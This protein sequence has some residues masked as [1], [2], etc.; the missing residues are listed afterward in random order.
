MQL[1]FVQAASLDI[2]ADL[3]PLPPSTPSPVTPTYFTCTPSTPT[4]QPVNVVLPATSPSPSPTSGPSPSPSPTPSTPPPAAP[5]TGSAP[6][7][8][9]TTPSWP[10]S[11]VMPSGT[12]VTVAVSAEPSSSNSSSYVARLDYY[13][14]GSSSSIGCRVHSAVFSGPGSTP[15]IDSWTWGIGALGLVPGG[16]WRFTVVAVDELGNMGMSATKLVL[17]SGPGR[18]TCGRWEGGG[19]GGAGAN[20]F[21]T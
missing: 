21:L 6:S 14:S 13:L 5:C 15:V 17:V 12:N 11:T 7:V 1:L 18:C 10:T 4:W 9:L 3:V 19:G 8:T 16:A 20:G 2:S